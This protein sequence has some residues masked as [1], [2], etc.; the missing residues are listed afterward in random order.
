MISLRKNLQ[1]GL[2]QIGICIM[3]PSAGVIERIGQDWDW[4]WLDGQHGQLGYGDLLNL[5]RACDL[6]QRPAFIRVP[7]H[8]FGTI[9]MALDT[10]AAG[11]IVPCVD[12]A[13]QAREIVNAAKFPPL[14]K[15]SYGGRRPIDR[16]GRGYYETANEDVCLVVQIESPEAI[17][18][19][20]A[21]A[22]LPG[23]DALFLGPDDISL[24]R[25]YDLTKPHSI[26]SLG[27]D[28][29][30]VAAACKKFNKLGFIVAANNEILRLSSELGF[31]MLVT[32]G[33]VPFLANSSKQRSDESRNA[34]TSFSSE[35]NGGSSIY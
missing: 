31:R 34:L 25:G 35:D 2:P 10:G 9:G 24:R 32:G 11:I 20:E 13:E 6:I 1:D 8:D 16:Q 23:V 22:A 15:R 12:T 17:E 5:V 7:G 30:K 28:M 19:V 14:G 27:A 4:I 3:Y 29:E 18:N 21:I 33:D 26:A